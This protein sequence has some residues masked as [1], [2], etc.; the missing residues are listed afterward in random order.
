MLLCQPVVGCIWL[1][2]QHARMT[3][4]LITQMRPCPQE[5]LLNLTVGN[6]QGVSYTTISTITLC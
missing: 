2:D 1:V 3:R 6:K 4:L 5:A